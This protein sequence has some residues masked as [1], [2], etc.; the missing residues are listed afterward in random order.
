MPNACRACIS[1]GFVLRCRPYVLGRRW[2]GRGGA[3]GNVRGAC[4]RLCRTCHVRA[5]AASHLSLTPSQM[6][7]R[8]TCERE[9]LT[10]NGNRTLHQIREILN[11]HKYVRV[12]A[13]AFYAAAAGVVD[14]SDIMRGGS[15]AVRD[16]YVHVPPSRTCPGC[17]Q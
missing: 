17:A 5:R 15:A 3:A 13:R 4:P 11:E 8:L 16:G 12:R 2:E 14:E 1:F 10:D 6:R 7:V 9:C